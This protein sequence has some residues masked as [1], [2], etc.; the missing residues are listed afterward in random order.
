MRLALKPSSS[1]KPTVEPIHAWLSQTLAEPFSLLRTLSSFLLASTCM[2]IIMTQSCPKLLWDYQDLQQV[3]L[4]TPY[5]QAFCF[6]FAGFEGS[7]AR[8]P[9]FLL[10]FCPPGW[11]YLASRAANGSNWPSARPLR[12]QGSTHACQHAVATG[13]WSINGQP[14]S[15]G[16]VLLIL[17]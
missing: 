11:Q 2:Q 13:A 3:D 8:L 16:T 12:P 17:A 5:C 6:F 9:F 1:S 4:M 10:F 7:A 14:A 15:R